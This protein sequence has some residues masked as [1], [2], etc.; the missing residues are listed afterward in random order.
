M[1]RMDLGP[2]AV[3]LDVSADT[4]LEDAV[5]LEKLGY[6]A[7][8]QGGGQLT[9][10]DP[11]AD[12]IRATSTIQV[13]PAIIALDVHGPEAV[14]SLYADVDRTDPERLIVG[15]GGPQ[16]GAKPLAAMNAFLDRLD[17]ATPPVP[18]DRRILAALGPRKLELARERF[19]G[20]MTLLTTPDYTASAREI[21]GPDST[22]I[23]EDLVAFDSDPSRA[24]ELVRGTVGFLAG[25]GGYAANFRRMGFADA[26]IDNVSDRLI[27]A[28][29]AW[30]DAEAIAARVRAHLDAGAD[31]VVL[32]V[33]TD[34]CGPDRLAAEREL[35]GL[36]IGS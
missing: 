22:L 2:I 1:P 35:A 3:A 11:L 32:G 18:V 23:V 9:T 15:L 14:A 36:L 31:Q 10:L 7:L 34:A 8:W 27:D 30:G 20:A 21:L 17:A 4:Y 29:V 33:Q 5:E 13:G 24:R 28:I 19:A 12:V 26:D 16:Q 25:V 6:A